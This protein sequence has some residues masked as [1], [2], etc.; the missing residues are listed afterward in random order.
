M[1]MR[2]CLY[3]H[4]S[5]ATAVSETKLKYLWVLLSVLNAGALE[6]SRVGANELMLYEGATRY[7]I[8]WVLERYS[9]YLDAELLQ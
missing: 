3:L 4:S 1:W 2:G 8:F 6:R 7:T 5:L 9:R